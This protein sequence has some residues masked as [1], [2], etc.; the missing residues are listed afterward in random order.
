MS[1]STNKHFNLKYEKH[2]YNIFSLQVFINLHLSF[3][4]LLL[5]LHSNTFCLDICL[6]FKVART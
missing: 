4:Y 2:Y 6:E 3:Q 5:V 1:R